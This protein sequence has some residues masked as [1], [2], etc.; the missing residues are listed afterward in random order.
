MATGIAAIGGLYRQV[1]VTADMALG[2]GGHFA[3]G[4]ELVRVGKRKAGAAVIENAVS[5]DG[6]GVASGTGRGSGRRKF[7]AT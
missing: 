2:A 1:V 5:P 7:A 6:D 3:S 4:R